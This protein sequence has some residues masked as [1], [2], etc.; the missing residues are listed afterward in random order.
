[1]AIGDPDTRP[2]VET[3]FIPTSFDLEYTAWDWEACAL[4]PWAMHLL[5]EVG[6]E[7]S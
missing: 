1:M 5:R 7:T 6:A 4:V 2:D 3:V